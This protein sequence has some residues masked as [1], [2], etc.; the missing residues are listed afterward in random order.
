MT[1]S[2]EISGLAELTAQL[3]ALPQ[4]MQKRIM[5]GAVA[6]AAAIIRQEAVIRA[7]QYTGPVSQGHP[8]PGTLKK[9]IYQTRLTEQCTETVETWA[10]KV[11][12][13]KKA[14]THRVKGVETNLDAYY[15][16]WV[17][18]GT[19]KMSARPFMRPAFEAKKDAAVDAMGTYIA[20]KLPEIV[21]SK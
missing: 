3:R 5:K 15:A 11:R 16:T 4:E 17:E 7:P 19:V 13:G 14:Q 1:T 8:P 12:H 10:V 21:T 2:T 9:A 18:Y 6:T 20:F